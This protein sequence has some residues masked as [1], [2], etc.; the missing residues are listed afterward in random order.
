MQRKLILLSIIFLILFSCSKATISNLKNLQEKKLDSSILKDRIICL[1]P[2]H[3]D[4][5]GKDN[6]RVGVSGEREEWINLRV[7][8]ILK[9]MLEDVGVK[10]IITRTEDVDVDLAYRANKAIENYADIF[11]SIHHNGTPDRDVDYPL[12]FF[13][14][15]ASENPA[16]IDFAKILEKNFKKRLNFKHMMSGFSLNDAG[17]Y[18]DHLIYKEGFAVIRKTYP[19]MPSA[20]G[21]ASFFSNPTQEQHLKQ[22]EYNELEAQAYFDTLVEYFSKGLPYAELISPEKN[23]EVRNKIST[24]LLRLWD[25]FG[26]H[27][28]DNN[29]FVVKVNNESAKYSYAPL[30]GELIL[31]SDEPLK[32]GEYKVFITARN[33]K[34]NA[35]HPKELKF[36][37]L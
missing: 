10:V 8:V 3:G 13:Y 5:A 4:T 9:K 2:G 23:S 32:P 6:F 22:K 7:S 36:K 12:V 28:F 30:T 14:G 20:I 15:K 24:I 18:S 17:I 29:S 21:E 27:Y 33:L 1:D 25:G 31:T 34:G 37:V 19:Y 26:E 11:I 16:S 35:M